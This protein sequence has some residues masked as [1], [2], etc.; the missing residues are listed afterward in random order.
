MDSKIFPDPEEYIPERWLE[1]QEINNRLDRYLVC[2]SKGSRSCLG[3]KYAH[4]SRPIL[5]RTDIRFSLA[6][7]ELYLTLATI[8]TRFDF[9]NFETTVDDVRPARDFFVPVPRLD[10]KGVRAR[11]STVA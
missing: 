11:L 1:A 4:S 5:Y 9:N 7:A 10:S 8:M 2:F 6:Y 3:I